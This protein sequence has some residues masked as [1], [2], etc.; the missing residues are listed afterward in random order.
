MYEYLNNLTFQALSQE[1]DKVYMSFKGIG[2]L[3]NDLLEC[4][5][6]KENEQIEKSSVLSRQ[7]RERLETDFKVE[8]SPELKIQWGE[9]IE[10]VQSST[11]LKTEEIENIYNQEKEDLLKTAI[12]I[13]KTDLETS[14]ENAE[15]S[16]KAVINE[17]INPT[18]GLIVDDTVNV[19]SQLDFEKEWF[20]CN[21]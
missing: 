21:F 17:I 15:N 4:F 1:N 18:P 2:L 9:L 20:R 10:P 11:P 19:D 16:N 12:T 13:N 14:V 5:D 3:V 6:K 8:L 7:L